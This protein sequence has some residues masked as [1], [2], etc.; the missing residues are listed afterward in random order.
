MKRYFSLTII[1]LS[2]KMVH[3][4]AQIGGFEYKKIKDTQENFLI[5]RKDFVDL[6][7]YLPSGFV[8]DGSQ[9]YTKY[10]QQA[11][12]TYNNIKFPNFPLLIND[13]GIQ[14]KSNTNLFFQEKSSLYLSPSSSQ[15]YSMILINGQENINL[16]NLKL[17]GDREKHRGEKGEHGM[18]L[19]VTNSK[20]I[21]IYNPKI[22]NTWGDGIYIGGSTNKNI[23]I[24]NGHID[25]VRRNGISIISA[26]QLTIDGMLIS[27]TNGTKPG[28]G[29]DI[30][31]NNEKQVLK[32]IKLLNIHTFNNKAHGIEINILKLLNNK[33]SNKISIIIDNHF[34]DNSLDGIRISKASLK[35]WK[36]YYPF[37]GYIKIQNSYWKNSRSKTSFFITNEKNL[38]PRVY[39]ENLKVDNSKQNEFIKTL[40][41]RIKGIDN[42]TLKVE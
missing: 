9:D 40:K 27:N 32:N 33:N 34:D 10:I 22:T 30:E 37:K 29:I 13:K 24:K 20:N 14:L 3:C 15:R 42:F 19:R 1:V 4:V 28:D 6:E 41:K 21:N 17:E 36:G 38:L 23:L 31:P 5:P 35:N 11:I 26:E 39:L 7:D 18:G 16:Y 8:K 12:D 2:L 25:N